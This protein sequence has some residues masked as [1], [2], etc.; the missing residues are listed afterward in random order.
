MNRLRDDVGD[1]PRSTKEIQWL[2]DTPPTP[3]MPDMKLRVWRALQQASLARASGASR[4]IFGTSGMKVVVLGATVVALAGTAGAMIA[5]RMLGG[6]M[7]AP[8][9]VLESSVPETT[10]QTGRAKARKLSSLPLPAPP[11]A[12]PAPV[13]A[14]GAGTKEPRSSTA[15]GGHGTVRIIAGPARPAVASLPART[16]VLDALVALRRDH[17]PARAGALLDKYLADHPRGALREEALVLAIEAADGLGDHPAGRRWALIY[18]AEFPHGRF[19]QFA[20]SHDQAKGPVPPHD[21]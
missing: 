20:R 1:D 17:D 8:A 14:A 7:L 18:Q 13:A 4:R 12:T 5:N 15:S 19:R 16:E 21:K 6:R 9:P 10:R 2:R 3:A 11:E